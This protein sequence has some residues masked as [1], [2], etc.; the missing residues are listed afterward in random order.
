MASQSGSNVVFK[1]PPSSLG[2][3]LQ[4][5]EYQVCPSLLGQATVDVVRSQEPPGTEDDLCHTKQF[6]V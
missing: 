5:P 6:F 1:R 4:N 3:L 2:S